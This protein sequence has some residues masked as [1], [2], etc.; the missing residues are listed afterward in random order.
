MNEKKRWINGFVLLAVIAGAAALAMSCANPAAGL[1]A[2]PAATPAPA[3]DAQIV[4]LK[5]ALESGK[6]SEPARRSLQEKLAMA[7]RMQ[8][9]QAAGAQLP[10]RE[11][12]APPLPQAA[13]PNLP[14]PL[15]EGIFDGSQGLVRPS[16]ADILNV[17]QGARNGNVFQVFA[18]SLPGDPSQGILLV[19]QIAPDMKRKTTWLRPPGQPGAL[20]IT[21]A[22]GPLLTLAGQ[23]GSTLTFNLDT[24]S[25]ED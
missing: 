9:E 11:K 16:S 24:L 20:R 14:E 21:A 1:R 19:V 5:T 6:L 17:W 2:E 4:Q 23:D 13:A 8:A 12:A 22:G 18:G 15:Q 3:D 10:R 7:E 25:F